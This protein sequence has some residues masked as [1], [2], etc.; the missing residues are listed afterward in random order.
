MAKF[1]HIAMTVPDPEKTAAFYEEVFELKRVR[2]QHNVI[3]LSD[4]VI[5]L[6]LIRRPNEPYPKVDHF[7]VE[8][9]DIRKVIAKIEEKGGQ[10]NQET[11]KDVMTDAE[12]K[13]ADPNGVVFDISQVGWKLTA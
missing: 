7:G 2:E 4:G 13:Y 1:R 10:L 8:V 5:N 12:I 11:P 3:M 9:D 6:A